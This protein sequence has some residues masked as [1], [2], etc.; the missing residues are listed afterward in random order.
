MTKWKALESSLGAF[1]SHVSLHQLK[2]EL[3]KARARVSG[4]MPHII[5]RTQGCKGWF[6]TFFEW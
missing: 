1:G 6:L 5:T 2:A 4:L 3:V